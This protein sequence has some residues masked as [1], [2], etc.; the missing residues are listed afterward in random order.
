LINSK[1]LHVGRID[2]WADLAM[3]KKTIAGSLDN[4]PH[5]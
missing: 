5:S 3:K 1:T 4:N 2:L